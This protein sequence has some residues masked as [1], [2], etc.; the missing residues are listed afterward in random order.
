MNIHQNARLTPRGRAAMIS[1]IETEGWS[2]ARAADAF[3]ISRQT[4]G[5][6]C[7]GIGGRRSV[8]QCRGLG[9]FDQLLTLGPDRHCSRRHSDQ[10]RGF[11]Q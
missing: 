4:V 10:R 1:R 3:V 5:N 11:N 7:N 9:A 8:G 2:V 6:G